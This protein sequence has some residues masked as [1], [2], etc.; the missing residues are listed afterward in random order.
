MK[1]GRRNRES[2]DE[3]IEAAPEKTTA[4]AAAPLFEPPP[5]ARG[6]GRKLARDLG[7]LLL[8]FVVGFAIAFIWLAP[9]PLLASDHATP[10]VV[11]MPGDQAEKLLAQAGFKTKRAESR[12][13][14]T[15]QAGKVIWQDPA[16]GTVL[17]EGTPVTVTV[18][19]GIAPY[20]VPD[21]SQLPLELAAR[22]IEASGFRMSKVDTA[23]SSGP[24]GVVVEV[25]PAI[26]SVQPAGTSIQ[27]VISSGRPALPGVREEKRP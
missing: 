6:A 15:Y 26:G 3:Q 7:L 16:A 1:F 5:S 24:A 22:V 12:Q 9:G 11:G 2:L 4:P 25:R 27:L 8:I 19:D 20:A 17:P 23:R 13:H 21:V 14:P 18:S 10:D